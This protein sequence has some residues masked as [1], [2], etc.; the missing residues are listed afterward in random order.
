MKNLI[1]ILFLCILVAGCDNGLFDGS[2]KDNSPISSIKGT[3]INSDNSVDTLYVIN[4][5]I[6]T[7]KSIYDG[8]QSTF[9]YFINNKNL[10]TVNNSAKLILF[11][12]NSL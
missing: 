4:D 12:A 6:F 9:K 10:T 3:W 5:S 7:K 11:T 2:S 1:A 8:I